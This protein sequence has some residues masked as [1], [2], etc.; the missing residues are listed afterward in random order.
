MIRVRQIFIKIENNTDKDLIKKLSQKLKVKESDVLDFKIN[1]RSLDARDK[2][3]IHYVYELDAKVKNESKILKKLNSQDILKTPEEKYNYIIKG[4]KTLNHRPIIIG[5]GP[6]GLFAAY[7]LAEAGYNPL[8]IEQ[9]EKIEDRLKTVNLFWTKN[10]LNENS[11]VQF[12][13]GGAGTFSDGKLNTLVKDKN[14]RMKKVFEIFVSCGAPKEILYVNN[15]HIGTDLLREVIINMRNKIIEMGGEFRYNAKLTDIKIKNNEITSITVNDKKEI[16]TNCLILAIGNSSR[17]TFKMLYQK[18][19]NMT[20]KP[21]AIGLRIAHP[22]D[23]IN[24]NQYG[25]KYYNK[26]ETASYK[27]TYTTNSKR[28]VYSFCMCPGGYVINASSSKNK[29]VINGMSNHQRDNNYS[30]SALVITITKDDLKDD[31]FSG[32][33]LQESLEEKAYLLGKGNIPT[34]RVQEFLTNKESKNLTDINDMIK[35]NYTPANLQKLFTKELNDDL[36]EALN[37]FETKITGFTN[38]E[39]I[40]FGVET[41]TSSPIRILRD[42]DMSSNIKGIYPVGEGSG[43]SGGITTSAI[44]GIKAFEKIIDQYK[45]ISH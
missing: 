12:G 30:N 10:I 43:Y 32:L 8:I 13:E 20:N 22:K 39:A 35:G 5:S 17:D 34:Q 7:F 41:R 28:G 31:V 6:A 19:L 23:L 2:N 45:P 11:N 14:N 29:L 18:G 1:K 21:F 40:L 16:P 15:P 42:E 33:K 44:D 38:K 24:K 25:E 37:N 36:K 9:G 27:L 4:E 3:N 26:L